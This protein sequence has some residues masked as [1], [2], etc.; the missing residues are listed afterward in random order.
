MRETPGWLAVIIP[1][2]AALLVAASSAPGNSGVYAL[3][4]GAP[5]GGPDSPF[6]AP[7]LDVRPRVFIRS[8]DFEGLTVAKLR[9]AAATPEFA[10]ARAKWRARPLGRA[11]LWMIEGSSEHRDAAI[12]GLRK[13][14]AS[15]G[16]W[17]DRGLA[18]VELAA[19][20]DW[21]YAEL[22]E[23]ARRQAALKI[24]EAADAAA[25]H[26]RG[27]QAP[28]FYSRTPGALAGLALAGLALK[29]ASDKADG[30]LALV[31]D[32]GAADYFKAYEW[33]DG[34]ATGATYTFFYTYVDLPALC[35]AWWSATGRNP[36]DWIARSQGD[37]LGGIVRFYLWYMRPGFAFTDANDQSRDIWGTHD[38]FCQGLD[39]AAYVTRSGHGRA[40]AGRWSGRFG[41]A[42]YHTEYAHNFMFRAAAPEPRALTD[43]PLAALFGRESCGY[44]FFRSAWPEDGRPDAATH[45]FF[46][47][48]DPVDV[49]GG[50]SAGEFQVF[51]YAPLAGR[52]GRYSSYD[53]PPDQYHRNCI[54]T[55]VVLFTDPS[56]GADRG[57][58][59]TRRGLKTDHRTWA[60]WL[61]IRQKCGL[62]VA[63][64]LEWQAGPAEARCRAD[65]SAANPPGRCRQ[66]VREFVWLARKHLVVLDVVETARPDVRRQ[67]QL[68]LPAAPEV[69]ERLLAVVN[70]P[71]GTKWAVPA[72]QPPAEEARLF[73]RTLLPR[74]Y[75][76]ILH[77]G[78]KAEAYGADGRAL[79]PAA[80]SEYHL[81]FG[82][83]VVQ[84]DPGCES[85]RTVFLHVLTAVDAAET[86]PPAAACRLAAPGRL[87]VTVD[88]AR[89][90]LAVPEWFKQ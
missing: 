67:W 14:D 39:I 10:D 35:A 13:M 58:Q 23:P 25:A 43:L 31:R 40:W 88:A 77:A 12:A 44:G 68:H 27:G 71:P 9:A 78:G 59:N 75:T 15:G 34:A 56:D 83:K 18:L 52:S 66:W 74:D 48:G 6:T 62:D 5:V 2:T 73:C 22:D 37:W 20:F 72:L 38:Q 29:G 1:A 50:V 69:G 76:L 8:D 36:A 55:N 65:L 32:W 19:L 3:A 45:V 7:V 81:K 61:A 46:R 28:F 33:L 11:L 51:R 86:A 90:V 4:A 57:D 54:S 42:L 24:E 89:T 79:G 17:S 64:I 26:V 80:G 70:R 60:E 84:I 41:P 30:Y 85:A 16:S 47:C 63:R 82:G 87:E 53:S 21:M 49:H